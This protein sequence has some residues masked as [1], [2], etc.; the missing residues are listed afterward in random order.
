MGG[1]SAIETATQSVTKILKAQMLTVAIL[2]KPDLIGGWNM[3]RA[4]RKQCPAAHQ[5]LRGQDLS[6]L[7]RQRSTQH[8]SLAC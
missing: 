3:P 7:E 6:N 5:Q 4:K 1:G 8:H 2:R